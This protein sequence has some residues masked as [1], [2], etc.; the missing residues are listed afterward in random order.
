MLPGFCIASLVD[1]QSCLLTSGHIIPAVFKQHSSCNHDG[2]ES[3]KG[4]AQAIFTLASD[5]Q[6]SV[7]QN[8]P[9]SSLSN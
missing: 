6:R 1:V 4:R 5:C 2:L 9:I 3:V 7:F 8:P